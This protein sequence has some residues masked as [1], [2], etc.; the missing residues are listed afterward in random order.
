M[1]YPVELGVRLRQLI[2]P[3]NKLYAPPPLPKHRRS[4]GHINNA[5]LF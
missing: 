4:E 5:F 2:Y 1:A 3:L